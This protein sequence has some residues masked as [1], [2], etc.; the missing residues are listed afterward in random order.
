VI[1]LARY[2]PRLNRKE[3]EWRTLKR[4]HRSHL[5]RSLRAVVDELVAGLHQLGGE[6]LDIVDEVPRWWIDGH[7]KE[8]TGRPPGWPMG[9]KDRQ[10]RSHCTNLA[11]PT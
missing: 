1:P 9:T 6:R 2:R 4:N 5:A 7:R 11:A 10:A 8:P 3:R